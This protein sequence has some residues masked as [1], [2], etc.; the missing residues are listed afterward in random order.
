MLFVFTKQRIPFS[1]LKTKYLFSKGSLNI[2]DLDGSL[3]KLYYVFFKRHTK[4][5]LIAL[6][7]KRF[8]DGINKMYV[9]YYR[10]SKLTRKILLGNVL[11][12]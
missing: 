3:Q 6:F 9:Y 5:A 7:K 4:Y 11:Y 10:Y 12:T 8:K 1:F 2:S